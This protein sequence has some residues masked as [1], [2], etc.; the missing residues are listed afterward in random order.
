MI[1]TDNEKI[2]LISITRDKIGLLHEY[3]MKMAK[4][5]KLEHEVSSTVEIL[6]NS[7]FNEEAGKVYF[8]HKNNKP[9]GFI[10]YGLLMST[11]TGKPTLYLEDIF[12]D[13]S[14]RG[15]GYGKLIFSELKK[16][17][18]NNNY[19]RMDWQC[20]DW[21]KPS[22]NFYLN[23]DAKPMDGW[24]MYRFDEDKLKDR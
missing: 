6:E 9:I 16:I 7:I 8:I 22:I 2:T 23:M 19:G 11:F 4:Y 17:A 15:N 10:L 20:L 12:I 14:E 5:E 24:T 21:N 18:V 13:E 3:I 1:Q